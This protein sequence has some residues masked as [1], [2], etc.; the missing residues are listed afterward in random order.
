[1]RY[2]LATLLVFSAVARAQEPTERF[3]AM[4]KALAAKS[5]HV[6]F[7]A[8]LTGKGSGDKVPFKGLLIMA[9]GNRARF[10]VAYKL[11]GKDL[12]T[13]LVCDGKT[14]QVEV[15]GGKPREKAFEENLNRNYAK[16]LERAGFVVTMFTV[17]APKT[18][19]VDL[20]KALEIR[21]LRLVR[22]EKGV[23][24]FAY[25]LRVDDRVLLGVELKVDAAT[26]LPLERT[27][28][29]EKGADP[30]TIR[31]VYRIQREPK[32]AEGVFVFP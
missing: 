27:L 5:L 10:E 13:K 1:M 14:I 6:D 11:L 26:H 20:A 3:A 25:K 23:D 9:E 24:V 12:G 29:I 16:M 7:D 19:S 32:L 8:E 2:A 15:K 4:E 18:G 30:A 22:A 31:E 28:V 17:R 21:D